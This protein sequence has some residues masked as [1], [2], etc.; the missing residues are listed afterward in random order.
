MS[1]IE[2][3]NERVGRLAIVG[4]GLLGGSLGLGLR[5]AGYA[6]SIVGVG[7]RQSTLDAAL[8]G[9]CIDQGTTDVGEAAAACDLIVL[10]TPLGTFAALLGQIAEHDHD[11]LI[12]TDLG[13]TKQMVC[14]DA[15]RLLPRPAR[16]VGSHP[17]AGG[18]QHGPQHARGDLFKNKPCVITPVGETDRQARDLVIDLWSLLGMRIIEMSPAEHDRKVAAISHLPHAVAAL[19]VKL[20][21]KQNALPLASTGFGDTTR[22]AS[23]DP[24]VW[25][26]IFTANREEVAELIGRMQVELGALGE[27]I[28][29]GDHD[30]IADAMAEAK[31]CRDEWIDKLNEGE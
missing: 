17:M 21:A 18:E 10:G 13:S 29:A 23:G 15:A 4:T 24:T 14:A 3:F 8:A 1:D 2:R 20:A 9:N 31:Q 7:R 22:V 11:R 26:D 5:A 28:A 19:L 27:I 6:G 30:R 16:F 25:A 12:I